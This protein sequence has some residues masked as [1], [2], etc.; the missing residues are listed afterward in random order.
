MNK[1][2]KFSLMSLTALG[3]LLSGITIASAQDDTP[4]MME[5]GREKVH[6]RIME[7]DTDGDG[8]ISKAEF[9]AGAE[10]RFAKLDQNSDGVISKEEFKQHHQEMR[11]KMQNFR[12]KRRQ[13]KQGA[14]AE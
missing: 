6:A 2:T 9:L 1:S 12:Q 5:K 14:E 11:E 7:K 8:A 4:A 13:N 10:E 3:V